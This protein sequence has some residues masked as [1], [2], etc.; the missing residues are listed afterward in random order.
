MV[1]RLEQLGGILSADSSLVV[2]HA[3]Q[4]QSIDLMKQSLCQLARVIAAQDKEA[5]A[6]RMTLTELKGRLQRKALSPLV[7]GPIVVKQ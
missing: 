4:L 5:V 2:R 1:R 3:Q 7:D 6:D